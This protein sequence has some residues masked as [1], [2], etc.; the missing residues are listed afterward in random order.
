MVIRMEHTTVTYSD[1]MFWCSDVELKCSIWYMLLE[2]RASY[3]AKGDWSA[4][5][6]IS[7][8]ELG[9]D[10][11]ECRCMPSVTSMAARR[12]RRSSRR[13]SCLLGVL[14]RTA[15]ECHAVHI[16]DDQCAVV[17]RCR[18]RNGL[19]RQT[20]R[21]SHLRLWTWS[22]QSRR[23]NVTAERCNINLEQRLIALRGRDWRCWRDAQTACDNMVVRKASCTVTSA[24]SWP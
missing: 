3:K 1:T 23:E 14:H 10:W 5:T 16:D 11:W 7:F 18:E 20:V 12:Y 21:R 19:L 13:G 24:T 15:D 4:C 22:H 8:G 9:D 6:Q 17:R 2:Y